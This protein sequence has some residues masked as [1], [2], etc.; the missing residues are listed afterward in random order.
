MTVTGEL[1]RINFDENKLFIRIPVT[2]RQLECSY[3]P[4]TEVDLLESRR[5]LIQVT[6]EFV[7]D[8]TGHPLRLT[9]VN[10]IEPV[11][12]SPLVF[13]RLEYQGTVL[14]TKSPLEI[15]PSLDDESQQFYI[16]SDES[17]DLHAF[18]ETRDSLVGEI[19]QH[20]VFAW[21]AYTNEQPDRLAPKAAE[22]AESLRQ[23]FVEVKHA[24]R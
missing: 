20:V 16:A 11:D 5:G 12:L 15:T 24:K 10:R 23:R 18:A 4:E 3:L 7:I 13:S 6:G 9:A 21:I 19:A 1:I 22:L 2:A 17:L 8:E 14:E